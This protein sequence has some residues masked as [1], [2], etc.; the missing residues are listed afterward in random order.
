MKVKTYHNVFAEAK[1]HPQFEFFCE[2]S[3][4]RIKLAETIYQERVAQSMTMEQLAELISNP[5]RVS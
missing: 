4:T 2:E 1:K 5:S 3:L